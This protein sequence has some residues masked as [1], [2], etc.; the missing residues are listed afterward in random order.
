VVEQVGEGEEAHLAAA[1]V[2]QGDCENDRV[3]EGDVVGG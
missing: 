1:A 3:E 2:I